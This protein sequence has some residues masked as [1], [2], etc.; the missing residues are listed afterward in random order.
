M[1][2]DF[3]IPTESGK[4]AISLEPGH[5]AIFVG[6]NGGG[7][8]RLAV[9]L[10][11]SMQASIHRISA[12]RA[13]V[14]NPSVTKT[15]E[16]ESLR[17]LSIGNSGSQFEGNPALRE[18][19]RWQKSMATSLL[20]DYDFLLQALFAEQSNKALETHQLARQGT[21]H[22]A[23]ATKFEKL[24]SIWQQV[25]PHRILHFTGDD[26]RVSAVGSESTYSASEMSDGERAI[27]YMIGQTLVARPSSVL[28]VDEPELHVH[29]SIMSKLWDE[30]EAART[31]C[32]FIFITH[33][34]EFAAVRSAQKFV[35]RDYDPKPYWIIEDVPSDT[36]FD[37]ELTTLILG[38][39][40]PILFVEGNE[41]TSLDVEI[42]RCCYPDWTVVPRGSCS[43]VIHS[44]VTMRKHADLTRTKCSGIV[45][46]DA[47]TDED[48]EFFSNLGIKVLPVSEIENLFLL[49]DVSRAIAEAEGYRE[50]ELDQRVSRLADAIFSEVEKPKKTERIIAEHCRRRIDRALKMI[51]LSDAKTI[52][53]VDAEYKAR[54][55]SLDVLAIARAR[56][57][58]I[59]AAVATRN[60]EELLSHYDDK[61]LLHLAASHLKSC[62]LPSFK[63]WLTRA[64]RNDTA[65]DFTK[66]LKAHLPT[67]DPA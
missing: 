54:T 44:V 49:P 27:F 67:L 45:D 6:A 28:I 32:G 12:H 5:S 34:L 41:S 17:G 29:R 3:S 53:A 40:R 50:E 13:L 10:E 26:I 62:K 8:T 57:E 48:R 52:D 35:I 47:H 14:L 33:D 25:L 36:G 55:G 61:N 18:T 9:Q 7:K 24:A 1:A 38:S 59:E 19:F 21:L 30:L 43:E 20:N 46:G 65:P 58:E 15:T 63:S 16:A 4:K 31:D 2:F 56:A 42:Y 64:L 39:R 23:E 60:V 51:D 22:A 66:A 11:R 37:E